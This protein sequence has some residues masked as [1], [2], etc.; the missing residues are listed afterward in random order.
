MQPPHT[1]AGDFDSEPARDALV[2]LRILRADASELAAGSPEL[3]RVLNQPLAGDEFGRT[4]LMLA[5]WYGAIR[6]ANL[7]RRLGADGDAVDEVGQP[8]TWYMANHGQG[9]REEQSLR[10]VSAE[11]VRLS[12]NQAVRDIFA[13]EGVQPQLNPIAPAVRNRKGL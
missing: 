5:Y 11:T 2:V 4:P 12:M 3:R 8:V 13:S 7:L 9:L 10:D 1:S 6:C